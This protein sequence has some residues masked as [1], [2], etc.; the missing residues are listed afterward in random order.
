MKFGDGTLANSKGANLSGGQKARLG[1]ARAVYNDADIL[2]LAA[3]D[4]VVRKE[5]FVRP[6]SGYV[7]ETRC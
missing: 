4:A 6:L 7:V 5:I 1:L 2:L 3:I